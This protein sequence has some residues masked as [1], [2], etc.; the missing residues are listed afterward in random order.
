MQKTIIKTII[1]KYFKDMS[2]DEKIDIILNNKDLREAVEQQYYEDLMFQQEEESKLMLGDNWGRYISYRD[3][4]SSF[5]LV[6]ED[7]RK[8]IDNL[9]SDYLPTEGIKLY[10]KINKK[11]VKLDNLDMYTDKYSDL[12]NEIEML[13]KDLLKICEDCL[14]EYESFTEEDLKEEIR[15]NLEEN[16]LYEDYYILDNDKSK[17]YVDISY[18]KTYE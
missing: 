14:H 12:E 1:K 8:F 6:L 13:C 17:V 10:K 4:Y 16:Y 3:N 15:F 2:T 18:T 7:W 11:I 5:F 9:D